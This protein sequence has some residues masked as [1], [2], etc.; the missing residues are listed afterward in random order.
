MHRRIDAVA[1]GPA[2]ATLNQSFLKGGGT[3]L[4]A[5]RSAPTVIG[6]SRHLI[7][8]TPGGEFTPDLRVPALP[9]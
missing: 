9:G 2:T 1:L 4:T 6:P 8:D 5:R 3:P 7:D